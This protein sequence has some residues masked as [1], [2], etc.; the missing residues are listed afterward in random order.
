MTLPFDPID[1]EAMELARLAAEIEIADRTRKEA[2]PGCLADVPVK[3]VDDY[4]LMHVG[5][6]EWGSC[7]CQRPDLH[8]ENR[9]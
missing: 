7:W 4:H 6:K 8:P 5:S 2:C 9:R 3:R 1:V